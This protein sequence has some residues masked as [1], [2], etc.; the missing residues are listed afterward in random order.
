M[1]FSILIASLFTFSSVSFS[2]VSFTILEP[3]TISG[4][5]E[6]T[7][8]GDAANWGLANLNDPLDA[9]TDTVVIVDDGTPGINAQGVPHANE[10]CS[11]INNDL[12]GKIAFVYRYDGVSSN[13][14]YAGTKVLNCQNAGAIGVIMVNRDDAVFGYD[15]TTDGPSTNIPFAFIT[16]TDGAIIRA[17]LDAG[18]D[19]VAF[20]GNKLGLHDDDAGIVKNTTLAPTEG[21][22]ASQTSLNASEFGFDIG[23]KIYNYG[24]N[25]QNN[26]MLTAKVTGA[27]GVWTETTGPYSIAQGDSVDVYTGG[28]N[29]IPAFSFANYPDGV[30]TLNYSIDLGITDESSFD[31]S[32]KYTFVI[33]DSIVSFCNMD[34]L[35]NLPKQNMYTRSVDPSFTACM[36]YNN[37]NGSRIGAT[38]IYFSA[39]TGWN[40]GLS[41]PGELAT[42]YLFEWNDNFVDINDANFG[43]TDLTNIAEG[44]FSFGPNDDE[45][46]VFAAFDDPVLLDDN[47][48]YLACLQVW[49]E[50]VWMGY[51]NRIEYS[52]NIEHYGQ[53]LVPVTNGTDYFYLGFQ[54]N[55]V[56]AIA[57]KVFDEAELSIDEKTSVNMNVYP[58]PTTDKLNVH[59]SNFVNGKLLITDISGRIIKETTF[60]G[61]KYSIDLSG[62]EAGQYLLIAIDENGNKSEKLFSKL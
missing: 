30:Y 27:G 53:P 34:T 7:S 61:N 11:T 43:F 1:K 16:K 10:G 44:E 62:F 31:N 14:C 51:N 45:K 40:S 39:T 37:P 8:N 5:Y 9:V 19:V 24:N 50:D 48:R 47:Q 55:L 46:I 2:Q 4:G 41:L 25:T 58:N 12:T 42:A 57:L 18:E 38:G 28:T 17:K 60:N 56:P 6:F 35:T 52:R 54:T 33:S 15:G 59:I 36:V 3:A 13:D 32:L 23:T 26:I 21:A 22:T 29:N 20:I 49:N